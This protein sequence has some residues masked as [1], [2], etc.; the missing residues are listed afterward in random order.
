LESASAPSAAGSPNKKKKAQTAFPCVGPSA[1]ATF[2]PN[3]Q[4]STP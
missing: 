2:S 3:R 4:K 1:R